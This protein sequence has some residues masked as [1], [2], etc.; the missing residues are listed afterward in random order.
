MKKETASKRYTFTLGN[1]ESCMTASM[2]IMELSENKDKNTL[3]D[4]SKAF[5]VDKLNT[6]FFNRYKEF[7][8]LF[9]NKLCENKK[10]AIEVFGIPEEKVNEEATRKPIRDFVKKMMG[11]MYILIT[12]NVSDFISE[13]FSSFFTKEGLDGLSY[14]AIGME[15]WRQ[16][17]YAQSLQR[18]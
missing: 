9:Y 11:R 7:Y 10:W 6:D 1:N 4:V 14:W 12:T 17:V 8:T 2:R 18:F 3:A 13:Y 16:R 15:G 5:S